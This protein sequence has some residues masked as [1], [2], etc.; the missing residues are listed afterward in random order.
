VDYDILAGGQVL[1]RA[2]AP[3][4]VTVSLRVPSPRLWSPASPTLYDLRVTA[5]GDTVLGYFGMRSFHVGHADGVVRPILNGEPTFLAGWLDQVQ[6]LPAALRE[7]PGQRPVPTQ[8][9]LRLAWRLLRACPARPP[10]SIGWR[11]P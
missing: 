4:G 10:A 6:M 11:L 3:P 2:T 5:G 9:A 8:L 7:L 1:A